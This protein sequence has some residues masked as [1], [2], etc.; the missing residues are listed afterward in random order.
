VFVAA[1]VHAASA[2]NYSFGLQAK[3]LLDGGVST[4]LDFASSAD[5]SMPGKSKRAM[6]GLDDLPRCAWITGGASD[7]SVRGDSTARN[8]LNSGANFVAHRCA[9]R[10]S[11][12]VPDSHCVAE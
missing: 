8:S 9:A 3:P 5:N 7:R 11:G 10:W 2:K 12:L 1:H 6:Q 4:K